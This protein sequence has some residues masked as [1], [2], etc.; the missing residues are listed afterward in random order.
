[1]TQPVCVRVGVR[2]VQFPSPFVNHCE[3]LNSEN[4]ELNCKCEMYKLK[5]GAYN[6]VMCRGMNPCFSFRIKKTNK[7]TQNKQNLNKPSGSMQEFPK[8]LQH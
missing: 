7:K 5:V 4:F 8:F 6:K 2:G 1:M 3:D